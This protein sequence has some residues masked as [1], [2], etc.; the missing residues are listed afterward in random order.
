MILWEAKEKDTLLNEL[1][2]IGEKYIECVG[3]YSL[4]N[5]TRIKCTSNDYREWKRF[6]KRQI[7]HT[8]TAG[9]LIEIVM[10]RVTNERSGAIPTNVCVAWSRT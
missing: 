5:T 2:C 7:Q 3:S 9:L 4:K 1:M 10:M 6:S 8:W